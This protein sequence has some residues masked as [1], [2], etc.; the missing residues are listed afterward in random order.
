MALIMRN[1]FI[2]TNIILLTSCFSQKQQYVQE[3]RNLQSEVIRLPVRG[4]VIRQQEKVEGFYVDK[5]SVFK[6]VVYADSLECSACAIN[7]IDSWRPLID[8]AKQFDDQLR[9]CFI[10]SPR[11]KDLLDTKLLMLRQMFDYP[12]LL[13]TLGEFEKLNPHLPKN[14][15]L[16]TFLLD[17]N[18]RVILVG[19]PLNNSK[20]KEMFYRVVEEKLGK[21]EQS[22]G[23]N[24][25]CYQ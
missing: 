4:L 10:F 25:S 11:K 17:E 13:D 6:L 23:E 16:H 7:H 14:K 9:Y 21:P 1:T 19:S 3:I 5:P 12:M 2:L 24:N 8:Y 22:V 20:I 15:V 18:N